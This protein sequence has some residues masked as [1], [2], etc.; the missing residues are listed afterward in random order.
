MRTDP[1]WVKGEQPKKAKKKPLH[2]KR[3]K[4][5]KYVDQSLDKLFK[6]GVKR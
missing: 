4:K 6:K 1:K 3:I 2:F 5:M